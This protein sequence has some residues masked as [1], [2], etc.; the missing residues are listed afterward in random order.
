M[1]KLETNIGK[2]ICDANKGF[3]TRFNEHISESRTDVSSCKFPRH[4]FQYGIK[5]GNLREHFVEI[6]VMLTTNDPAKSEYCY[7]KE[8][9]K[10]QLIKY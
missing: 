1:C 2:S 7:V 3:K 5:Y 10:E 8:S 9:F 6:N 4:D